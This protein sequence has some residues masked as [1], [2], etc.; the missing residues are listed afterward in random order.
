MTGACGA[1]TELGEDPRTPD[2]PD[3]QAACFLLVKPPPQECKLPRK[4]QAGNRRR[5]EVKR[6]HGSQDGW[7]GD[8]MVRSGE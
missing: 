3:T 7:K 2:S 6:G 5:P 1:G 4:A 8:P